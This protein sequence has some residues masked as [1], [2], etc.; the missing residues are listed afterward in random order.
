MAHDITILDTRHDYDLY[1]L[2]RNIS[3]GDDELLWDY[4]DDE[5][6]SRTEIAKQKAAQIFKGNFIVVAYARNT[7]R[8]LYT[9]YLVYENL[10]ELIKWLNDEGTYEIRIRF[11]GRHMLVEGWCHDGTYSAQVRVLTPKGRAAF[12]RNGNGRSCYINSHYSVLPHV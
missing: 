3:H 9:G 12:D 2:C 7:W 10:D 1:E 4:Y 6:A 5:M 11:E 8:G